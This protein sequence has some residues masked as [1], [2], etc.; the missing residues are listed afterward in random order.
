MTYNVNLERQN[1]ARTLAA[2]APTL[3]ASTRQSPLEHC[4][5]DQLTVY[6][7][8]IKLPTKAALPVGRTLPGRSSLGKRHSQMLKRGLVAVSGACHGRNRF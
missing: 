2:V 6:A 4:H 8:S 1:C 3:A 5:K 7:Y